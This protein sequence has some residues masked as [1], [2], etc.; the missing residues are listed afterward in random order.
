M[1]GIK[2]PL[3]TF[4]ASGLSHVQIDNFFRYLA[5]SFTENVGREKKAKTRTVSTGH[6]ET[7]GKE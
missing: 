4:Q 2:K 3:S 6:H 5:S 7:V 1:K